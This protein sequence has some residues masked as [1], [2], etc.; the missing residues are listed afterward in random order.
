MSG[1]FF[2]KTDQLHIAAAKVRYE[3]QRQGGGGGYPAL[4]AKLPLDFKILGMSVHHDM[5]NIAKAAENGTPVPE[6]QKM[7]S[8]T[9]IRC[10]ACH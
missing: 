9:L 6:I 4:M 7:L 5:D 8:N 3:R 10:V 2:W 1:L